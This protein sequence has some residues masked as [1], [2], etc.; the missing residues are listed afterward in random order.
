MTD[1]TLGRLAWFA[2][3][4][5]VVLDIAGIALELWHR[6][7]GVHGHAVDPMVSLFIVAAVIGAVVASRRPRNAVGWVLLAIGLTW[8]LGQFTAGYAFHSL[9]ASPR[10]LPRPDVVL[11]V[12]ASLWVPG[13]GLIGTFLILLFPDG[14]LPTPRWRWWGRLCG[15]APAVPFASFLVVPGDYGDSGYPQVHNPFGI[16]ALKP[17]VPVLF[18]FIALIPVG[19][20]GCA[21]SVVQR[22]RRSRGA[23]RQQIK[24]LAAAGAIVAVLYLLVMA[25]RPVLFLIGADTEPSWIGAWETIAIAPFILIPTAVGFA[26]LRY[27]LYDIDRIISRTVS[28]AIVTSLLALPYFVVVPVVTRVVGGSSLAVAAATLAVA[29]AFNPLRRRVQDRVDRRFNRAR[30]DAARTVDSFSAR[31]RDD[32]QLESLTADLLD[33]VHRTVQ[34]S[35]ASLWLRSTP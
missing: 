15:V 33:V 13:I 28:Y 34:P 31:L 11:A 19:I 27:R 10:S 32:V 9:I 22:F 23:E 16:A 14:H 2:L 7:P 29:A 25:T 6:P 4:L 30:Y 8:T 21:V 35:Y 12:D 24:W 18:G 5:A 1:R 3:A 17:W 20:V 26:M